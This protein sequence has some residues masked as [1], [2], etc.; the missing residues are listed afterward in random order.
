MTTK[1][2]NLSLRCIKAKGVD[3][4]EISTIENMIREIIKID[5]GQIVEIG[6]YHSVVGYNMDRIT[7]S[8]QGI[9][10]TIEAILKEE[11]LEGICDQ[12][13]I[14]EFKIIEVDT[15]VI[16][17]MIIMEKEEVGQ[18]IDSILIIPEGMMEVIVGLDQV[19]EL[20]PIEI[21]LWAINI[22]I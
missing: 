15:E 6:E 14:I 8:D 13:R 20:V 21:E 18:G 12:L 3:R 17:E 1:I 19:H 2:S 10:R 5:I 9:I 11:I 16:I 7:E 22:N 4:Q